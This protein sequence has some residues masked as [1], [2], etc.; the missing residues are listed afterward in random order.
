M[1]CMGVL[2]GSF[3][4]RRAW[5]DP[6]AKPHACAQS[7]GCGQK[8]S[9]D[10]IGELVEAASSAASDVVVL[11]PG[12]EGGLAGELEALMA[13]QEAIDA[14]D[15]PHV[16]VYTSAKCEERQARRGLAE[17]GSVL[18]GFGAYTECGTLC[19]V[20]EWARAC[21]FVRVCAHLGG[22]DA[23]LMWLL[24]PPRDPVRSPLPCPRVQTQV[25]W[26]EGMLSISFLAISIGLG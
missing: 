17:A 11:C 5:P 21:V 7:V 1:F 8:R 3:A 14:A 24:G 6:L 22:A 20:G 2:H 13:V 25:R 9:D 19:Q 10:L 15:L 18:T 26:L 12:G 4:W 23:A 16:L